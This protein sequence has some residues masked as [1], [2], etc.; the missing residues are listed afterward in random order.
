MNVNLFSQFESN[1]F[2]LKREFNKNFEE[3]KRKDN[4]S[5]DCFINEIESLFLALMSFY[6][7]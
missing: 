2:E 1:A 6:N 4:F 7:K 3:I 5:F